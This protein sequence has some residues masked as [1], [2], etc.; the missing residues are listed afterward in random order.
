MTLSHCP[1][2]NHDAI[3]KKDKPCLLIHTFRSFY[4]NALRS[5]AWGLTDNHYNDVIMSAMASQI[6]GVSIVYLTASWGA[7]QIK[8]Q[9]FA[10]LAFVRGIHRWQENS[11]YKGSVTWK[12]FPLEDVIIKSTLDQLMVWCHQVTNPLL[13]PILAQIYIA[14]RR[15]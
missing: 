8:H 6:T 3:F 14:I 1:L 15:H 4:E 7:D 12:M 11:P 10:S 9:S 2:E 13:E 5:M